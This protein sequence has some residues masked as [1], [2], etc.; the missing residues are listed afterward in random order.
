MI[1]II[2]GVKGKGKTK[3][4][5]EKANTTSGLAGGTVIYLDKSQKHMY[6]LNNS[7]RLINVSDYPIDSKNS[8]IGLIC[9][10]LSGNHDIEHVFFDSFLKIS[11]LQVEELD[12]IFEELESLSKKFSVS[13][14]ISLSTDPKELSNY[15]KEFITLSL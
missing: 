9:G 2:A 12:T 6:E 14:V 15:V 8:F 3:H 13:F 5:I 7:I 10:L 4:L 1:E 11:C